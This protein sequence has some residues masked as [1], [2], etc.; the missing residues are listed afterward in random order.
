M[1]HYNKG[2][3]NNNLIIEYEQTLKQQC[4]GIYRKQQAALKKTGWGLLMAN[5]E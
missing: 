5:N 4:N 3:D 1:I 2:Q